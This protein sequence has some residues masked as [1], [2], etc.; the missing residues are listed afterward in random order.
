[1]SSIK[2]ALMLMACGMATSFEF[3]KDC[4]PKDATVIELTGAPLAVRVWVPERS[5][6]EILRLFI[7]DGNLAFTNI[8][9]SETVVEIENKGQHREIH[10]LEEYNKTIP[11]GWTEFQVTVDRK[12]RVFVPAIQQTIVDED[13]FVE[14][15][16]LHIQGKQ[17][18]VNCFTSL[19]QWKVALGSPASVPLA[20][21]GPH[22]FALYSRKAFV[23]SLKVGSQ[24]LHLHWDPELKAVSAS[25]SNPQPLPAFTL[26]NF[27]LKCEQI[28]QN[29][30]CDVMWENG[31][32]EPL[33]DSV[34]LKEVDSLSFAATDK[35]DYVVQYTHKD[36]ET[37]L[38]E[39]LPGK[40]ENG[41]GEEDDKRP[42]DVDGWLIP[43]FWGCLALSVAVFAVI[44]QMESL[45][46]R[47][48]KYRK[49]RNREKTCS[50][51]YMKCNQERKQKE[52][53]STEYRICKQEIKED[54]RSSRAIRNI[55]RKSHPCSITAASRRTPTGYIH[56]FQRRSEPITYRDL[57]E[58][59]E[60]ENPD[61]QQDSG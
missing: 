47:L 40:S 43:F 59:D 48:A 57:K 39:K 50:A 22:H 37:T 21:L 7:I 23:P 53:R 3:H 2:F 15:D 58:N 29:W 19:T 14:A 10:I 18:T 46:R 12:F 55:Q 25:T 6:D 27:T 11:H 42:D 1:M 4:E 20:G 24:R 52:R 5:D 41:A 36:Q 9:I 31:G 17:V 33:V 45:F 32:H 8:H 35:I 61:R 54:V 26:H 56:S 49:E 44:I 38:E 30:K 34:L 13:D 60:Q 16:T 28:P 51:E